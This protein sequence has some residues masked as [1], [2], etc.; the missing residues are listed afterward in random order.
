MEKSGRIELKPSR[1]LH[2]LLAIGGLIFVGMSGFV[3]Y[4]T[5]QDVHRQAGDLAKGVGFVLFSLSMLSFCVWQ[6]FDRRERIAF[7][8]EGIEDRV[9][10]R[11]PWADVENATARG[12][13]MKPY[14]TLRLRD[15]ERYMQRYKPHWRWLIKRAVAMGSPSFVLNLT[16]LN[17]SADK[18]VD[19]IDHGV[20]GSWPPPG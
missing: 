9:L 17:V 19:I 1:R 20:R 3:L 6:M 7:N 5:S 8:A 2:F 10:G 12:T 18:V 14:V 16:G 15:E 13:V 11:I 4:M